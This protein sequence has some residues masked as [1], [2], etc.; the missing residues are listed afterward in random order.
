MSHFSDITTTV[1]RSGYDYVRGRNQQIKIRQK[2]YCFLLLYNDVCSTES[3]VPNSII[4]Y[5]RSHITQHTI[6][7]HEFRI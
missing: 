7:V 2:Q 5:I 1:E 6:N 4:F 3:L